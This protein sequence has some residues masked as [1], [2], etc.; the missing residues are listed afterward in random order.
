[1]PDDPRPECRDDKEYT[2]KMAQWFIRQSAGI[3]VQVDP[4]KSDGESQFSST[5]TVSRQNEVGA[6]NLF[7]HSRNAETHTLEEALETLCLA[8]SSIRAGPHRSLFDSPAVQVHANPVAYFELALWLLAGHGTRNVRWNR[9]GVK[10]RSTI[11]VFHDLSCSITVIIAET[12]AS[13]GVLSRI[14]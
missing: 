3:W 4:S 13:G 9:S 11:R 8:S 6:I 10:R 12:P 2:D 7:I 1:M 5:R 14:A